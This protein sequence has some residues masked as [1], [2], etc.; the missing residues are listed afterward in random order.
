VGIEDGFQRLGSDPFELPIEERD[1]TRRLR[2]RLAMPVTIWTAYEEEG[3]PTGLT[4]SSV[5]VSEGDPPTVLGLVAPDSAFWDA[6]RVSKRFV[7][8]VLDSAHS[9]IADQFALRYPGDPFEGLRTLSSEYGP[10]VSDLKTRAVSSLMGY[11]ESGSSLLIRGS[12]EEV[13]LD[14]NPTQPLVHFRGRYLTTAARM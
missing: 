3:L 5:L 1:L 4:M 10:V 12:L 11:I 13:E 2:G 8:H 6:V 7:V 14:P 9:R